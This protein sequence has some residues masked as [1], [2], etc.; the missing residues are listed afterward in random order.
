MDF[1]FLLGNVSRSSSLVDQAREKGQE[2]LTI[3]KESKA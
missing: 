1:S 2:A 3:G